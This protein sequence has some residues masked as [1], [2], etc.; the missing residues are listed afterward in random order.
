MARDSA[1]TP[2]EELELGLWYGFLY[3]IRGDV[4]LAEVVRKSDQPPASG[5]SR[6]GVTSKDSAH[7]VSKLID[8]LAIVL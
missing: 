1:L 2:S 8:Y 4:V 6:K 3:A 7:L 5:C